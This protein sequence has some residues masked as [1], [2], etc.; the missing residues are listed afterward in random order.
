MFR[1]IRHLSRTT[2]GLQAG[3]LANAIALVQ[4]QNVQT[5]RKFLRET[6]CYLLRALLR[7]CTYL[8]DPAARKYLP[9]HIVY[10]FRKYCP[11]QHPGLPSKEQTE[12]PECIKRIS[13]LF[14]EGDS[15]L[16]L[17]I[18]ANDGYPDELHKVLAVTYGRSGKRKH[19]LLRVLKAEDNPLDVTSLA[20]LCSPFKR[21]K[22]IPHLTRTMAAL[23]KSQKGQ[24]TLGFDKAPIKN[25]KPVIDNENAWGRPM[26][27]NR[28]ENQRIKWYA[29]TLDALLPPLPEHEWQRLGGL[30][31]GR[32]PW[33]GP[34]P[35]R[36]QAA[37]S[38][39]S[40]K[41][42]HNGASAENVSKES[43][44]S[45]YSFWN[46]EYI[47]DVKTNPHKLTPRYMRN[48]WA[49]VFVQCPLMTWDVERKRWNVQ[50]GNIHKD[51][52]LVLSSRHQKDI[53]LLME[54]K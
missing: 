30:A 8:P 40:D 41:E 14:K 21:K 36:R 32:V 44:G 26:P 1:T 34:V 49:R 7:Q 54:L 11:R 9:S 29:M 15:K 28:A 38:A 18:R 20:R 43:Q 4:P 12:D 5:K 37:V 46:K 2:R 52:E 10:R 22:K 51:K 16:K 48:L 19:E 23:A 45:E 24:K 47:P 39:G 3:K 6:T 31:S 13:K 50:W 27:S 53:S 33:E 25:L 42:A 17:L 35:R